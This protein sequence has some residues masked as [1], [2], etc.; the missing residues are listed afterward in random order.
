MFAE[1]LPPARHTPSAGSPQDH[2]MV[3]IEWQG[4]LQV[5][6]AVWYQFSSWEEFYMIHK[7]DVLNIVVR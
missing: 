2:V 7:T 1:G 6:G 4:T 5:S 3:S